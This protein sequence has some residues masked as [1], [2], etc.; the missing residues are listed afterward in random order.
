[1]QSWLVNNTSQHTVM[2]IFCVQHVLDSHSRTHTSVVLYVPTPQ[3]IAA[4]SPLFMLT[5]LDDDDDESTILSISTSTFTL[6]AWNR[7]M[8]L[9]A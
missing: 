7:G 1:M 6:M 4:L 8:T 2:L 9:I 3:R 5:C